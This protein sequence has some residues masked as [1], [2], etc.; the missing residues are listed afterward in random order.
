MEEIWKDIEGYEK[1]YQISNFGR[2]R[3]KDRVTRNGR[4]NKCIRKGKVLKPTLNQY[5][6]LKIALWK[7]N[8][9][10]FFGIHRLV[11]MTFLENNENKNEINHKDGNKTNNCIDNLEWVDRSENMKHAVRMGLLQTKGYIRKKKK[12]IQKDLDGNTIKIWDSCS[13]IV[14]ERGFSDSHIYAC[15]KRKKHKKTAYGY[16]WEYEKELGDRKSN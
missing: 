8:T 7:E 11:A 1:L 4:C 12:I 14:R 5:G 13:D 9:T 6:Y 10:K 16:I 3:S 2:I 15:C